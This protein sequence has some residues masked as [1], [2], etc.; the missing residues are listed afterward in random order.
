[1]YIHIIYMMCV[2][3]CVL[4]LWAFW[5]DL[6]SC[7][8]IFRSYLSLWQAVLFVY[9]S[10][11]ICICLFTYLFIYLPIYIYPSFS[12]C[13][14]SSSSVHILP[15]KDVGLSRCFPILL[16]LCSMSN[17]RR[18]A[19]RS[20]DPVTPIDNRCASSQAPP[21]ALGASPPPLAPSPVRCPLYCKTNLFF[22]IQQRGAPHMP[23]RQRGVI[24]F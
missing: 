21:A 11:Y 2:Y 14:W 23:Y 13:V 4:C 9:L 5:Y 10:L 22:P 15:L 1:M 17:V 18:S 7:S 12:L 24:H 16:T 20:A 6:A 8:C 19:A 3:V